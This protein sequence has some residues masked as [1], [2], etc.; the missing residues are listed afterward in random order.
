MTTDGDEGSPPRCG[1]YFA[2]PLCG[3]LFGDRGV[4]SS[5]VVWQ[6]P[7]AGVACS[8]NVCHPPTVFYSLFTCDGVFAVSRR[9]GAQNGA[10]LQAGWS[11]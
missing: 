2:D 10:C 4:A 11:I 6:S 3:S 8:G 7:I 5:S 9:N 1:Q